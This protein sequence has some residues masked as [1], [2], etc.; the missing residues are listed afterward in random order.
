[1]TPPIKS[2]ENDTVIFKQYSLKSIK[3][4]QI[5]KKELQKELKLKESQDL[6]LITVTTELTDSLKGEDVII[7]LQGLLEI[8]I[9]V[10]LRARGSKKYQKYAEELLKKYPNNFRIIDDNDECLRK[11]YAGGD[12]SIFLDFNNEE[13]IENCMRYGNIPVSVAHK[14]LEDFNAVEERGNAFIITKVSP[15]YIFEAVVRAKENFKFPYD[16]KNIQKACIET[17]N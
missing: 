8:G 10:V 9:Q 15:W 14:D 2:P 7:A 3:D 5:N 13:E 1:M 6:F 11:M 16:W 12:A 4:K 17:K